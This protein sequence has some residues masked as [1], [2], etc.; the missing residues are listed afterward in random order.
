MWKAGINHDIHEE[1][2]EM[3]DHL[4]YLTPWETLEWMITMAFSF[5]ILWF[6]NKSL[7]KK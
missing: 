7:Y 5:K 4:F 3:S 1:K 6:Y 2:W